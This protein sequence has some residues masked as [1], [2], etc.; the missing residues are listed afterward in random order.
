MYHS[1]VSDT[2]ILH[3]DGD[4]VKKHLSVAASKYKISDTGNNAM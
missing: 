2:A 1:D 4:D 3:H